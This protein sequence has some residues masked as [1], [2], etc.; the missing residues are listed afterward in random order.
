MGDR[1]TKH[2]LCVKK[3]QFSTDRGRKIETNVGVPRRW[4]K[5]EQDAEPERS[6]WGRTRGIG[7]G[8]GKGEREY[9]SASL[10]KIG[11]TRESS[12]LERGGGHLWARKKK[13]HRG[14]IKDVV[15]LSLPLQDPPYPLMEGGGR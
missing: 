1:G 5:K 8:E 12:N 4:R 13:N 11:V 6:K 2:C 14:K 10:K 15:L 9:E 7:G 3:H